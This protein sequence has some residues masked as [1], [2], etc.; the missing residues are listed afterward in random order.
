MSRCHALNVL[1]WDLVFENNQEH[2]PEKLTESVAL[3]QL[4]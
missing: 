1:N 4:W 2:L 3:Y